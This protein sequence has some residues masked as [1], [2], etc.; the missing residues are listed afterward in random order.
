MLSKRTD[1][2]RNHAIL[3][4]ASGVNNLS[5]E[6][7]APRDCP[8]CPGFAIFLPVAG[9]SA[10]SLFERG[11]C[12]SYF[13]Y[14]VLPAPS[15]RRWRQQSV[16][17]MDKYASTVAD[18]MTEM[19]L[20]GWDFIGAEALKER[21]RR[22]LIL[23]C[24]VERTLMIFRRP[25]EVHDFAK[26]DDTAEIAPVAEPVLPRRVKRPELVAEVAAGARRVQVNVVKKMEDT[27]ADETPVAVEDAQPTLAAAD[28]PPCADEPTG[29]AHM[30][31]R[32]VRSKKVAT[33]VA[34]E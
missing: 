17:G 21:R 18:L 5:P 33:G 31:E 11:N 24:D 32:A 34:A 29:K 6:I 13:E 20:E 27:P 9:F 25:A 23:V 30:L 22:F 4:A 14:K 26:T 3:A 7:G 28:T 19:G 1:F 16:D 10:A 8:I 15:Q 2:R 12:M